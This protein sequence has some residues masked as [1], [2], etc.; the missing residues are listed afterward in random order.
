MLMLLGM[1]YTVKGKHGL[2]WTYLRKAEGD[3]EG[4]ESCEFTSELSYVLAK[5]YMCMSTIM[6]RSHSSLIKKAEMFAEKCR[7]TCI[8]NLE[9]G[10]WYALFALESLFL[11]L[12]IKLDADMYL[13]NLEEKDEEPL[14]EIQLIELEK[15]HKNISDESWKLGNKYIYVTLG[16]AK[17]DC[18]IKIKWMKLYKHNGLFRHARRCC[19]KASEYV[20]ES[21]T[22]CNSLLN[23]DEGCVQ[24][25]Y[26]HKTLD[27]FYKI[28]DM[29]KKF[30][31]ML[32]T[33][34]KAS[35][36]SVYPKPPRSCVKYK[37]PKPPEWEEIP[38]DSCYDNLKDIKDLKPPSPPCSTD[39][40]VIG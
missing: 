37:T 17:C 20:D 22:K 16:L 39:S 11:L 13:D 26:V 12:H 28:T 6:K 29:L 15:L 25:K 3:L 31:K 1:L 5:Y 36:Q 32:D 19:E 18:I 9:H 7:D 33:M 14:D 40:G 2:A 27:Q 23:A 34:I 8:E 24:F 35:E 38:D 21:I 4:A 10:E 30:N